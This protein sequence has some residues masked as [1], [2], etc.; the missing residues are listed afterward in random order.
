MIRRHTGSNLL[1]DQGIWHIV[2][3][4]AVVASQQQQSQVNSVLEK[5]KFPGINQQV[6]IYS[7]RTKEV[8]LFDDGIQ[9]K[10]Q[11]PKRDNQPAEKK[12]RINTD[13]LTME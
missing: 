11:K 6:D 10:E 13:V 5:G 8:L 4:K 9:V 3:E 1:S 12:K 2:V 7:K